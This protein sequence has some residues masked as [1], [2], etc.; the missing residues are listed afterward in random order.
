MNAVPH[1]AGQQ[2]KKWCQKS[3]EQKRICV[4]I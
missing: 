3:E 1:E 2:P 4:L